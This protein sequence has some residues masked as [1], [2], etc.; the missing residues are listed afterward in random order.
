MDKLLGDL[1]IE[2]CEKLELTQQVN[3]LGKKAGEG[4]TFAVTHLH[5]MVTKVLEEGGKLKNNTILIALR[6]KELS[7]TKKLQLDAL[8]TIEFIRVRELANNIDC[9]ITNPKRLS[10]YD[11]IE[12]YIEFV[13]LKE[14]DGALEREIKAY[15]FNTDDEKHSNIERLRKRLSKTE[16]E[17]LNLIK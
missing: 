1:F 16:K 11:A 13:K 6:L 15:E 17:I 9:G 12:K 3:Y 5:E 14:P 8:F 4:K 7:N 10:D 2:E